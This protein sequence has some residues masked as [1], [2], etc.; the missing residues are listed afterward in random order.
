MP[1][2]IIERSQSCY[3]LASDFTPSFIASLTPRST[4]AVSLTDSINSEGI[5]TVRIADGSVGRREV[6][7]KVDVIATDWDNL[8]TPIVDASGNAVYPGMGS[9]IVDGVVAF[10]D[11]NIS[12][13]DVGLSIAGETT[14]AGDFVV[15]SRTISSTTGSGIILSRDILGIIGGPTHTEV[16]WVDL[17]P[18]KS[19]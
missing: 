5:P 2:E 17:R 1:P 7:G 11:G 15:G 8:G 18:S 10:I 19:Q 16:A 4:L 13:R 6:Y 9:I 12:G 3:L 14:L